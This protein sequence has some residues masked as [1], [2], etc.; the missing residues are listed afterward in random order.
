M[1]GHQRYHPRR[2]VEIFQA[3]PSAKTGHKRPGA[4]SGV[5]L[6]PGSVGEHNLTLVRETNVIEKMRRGAREPRPKMPYP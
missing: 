6:V 3:P 5:I 1:C 2:V 4:V